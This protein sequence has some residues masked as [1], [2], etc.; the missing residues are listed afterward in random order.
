MKMVM[1]IFP[2]NKLQKII[3]AM[4]WIIPAQAINA[5]QTLF[6]LLPAQKTGVDFTN[7]I[8]EN[9]SLH[10]M[11]YEYLYNGHG[12]GIGDFNNDD[13]EDIFIS[14]NAVPNKLFLNK[15]TP[16]DATGGFNFEDVQKRPVLPVMAPGAQVWLLLM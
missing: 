8:P 16:G 9:N 6:T 3:S 13:F 1:K 2:L 7:L 10:I 5:Q 11:N 15:H 4:L 14:G 12:I